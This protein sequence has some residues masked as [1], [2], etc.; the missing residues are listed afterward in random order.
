MLKQ[1]NGLREQVKYAAEKIQ[2]ADAV[3]IGGGSGLSSAAGYNHYHHNDIFTQYFKD[4]EDT[5]G[6]QNLFQGFYYVYSTPEQQWGFYSRYIQFMYDMPA[7]KPYTDL[8]AMLKDKDYFIITTNAD[9][10]FPR[11]FPK[12]RLFQFQGDFRYFQCC[13]PCHDRLYDN[14]EMINA[15][16]LH[17]EHLQVPETYLPRCP[18]CGWRMI[19]WVRDNTFLTGSYW[20]SS[21]DRYAEFLEK[22]HHKKL[23][24]LELGVGE[25]TPSIIKLP[26]WE[27][28]A[29]C[30][31][32][33]LIT[34]NQN[35]H[36][37]PE[38]LSGKSMTITMDIGEFLNETGGLNL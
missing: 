27:I 5:Y 8:K 11:V 22:N 2:R 20:N 21:H 25:M 18:E 33:F 7:R 6:I 31:D 10:Q 35:K 19:P 36:S 12:E 23:V 3:L 4:F 9:I 15:M 26:F 28:T 17:M 34:V 37:R 32:A 38:Q 30:P 13:Q 16:L 14:R 1:C 29:N 24:L